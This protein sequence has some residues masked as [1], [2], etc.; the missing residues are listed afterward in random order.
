M[1]RSLQDLK[2]HS[3]KLDN[4]KIANPKS[5]KFIAFLVFKLLS[6]QEFFDNQKRQ[7]NVLKS[8]LLFKKITNSHGY[9]TVN[10]R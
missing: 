6:R 5:F 7:Q 4:N 1:M 3:C 9:I 2:L 10:Y 8:R